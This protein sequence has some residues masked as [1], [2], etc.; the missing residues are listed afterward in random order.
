MR[1]GKRQHRSYPPLLAI[2]LL[3]LLVAGAAPHTEGL[4]T[5]AAFNKRFIAAGQRMD[6]AELKALIAED[7]V[8]LLPS[9]APM[10][11]K[12]VIVKWIDLI[13]DQAASYHVVTNVIDFR[14]IQV[15]GDWATEWGPTHQV[16]QPGNGPP[17]DT[18]GTM[19]LVLHRQSHGEWQIQREMWANAPAPPSF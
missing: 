14:D 8:N 13:A 19:L 12:K 3:G 18:Y 2:A 1:A 10:V 6:R 17:F 16:V 9:T 7:A 15:C 5:I 11:G 4:K